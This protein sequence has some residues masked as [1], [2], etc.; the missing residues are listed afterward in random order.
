M[1]HNISGVILAG[2]TNSRFHGIT[3]ANI[4]IC[5]KTIISRITETINEIFKEIII[6]TNTPAEFTDYNEY[7]IV[8]DRYSNIGPLGG[9]HA[10]MKISS[11]ESIFIFAGDMPFLD[12]KLILK[13][14]D[15]HFSHRCDISVPRISDY[16]EPLHSIYNVSLINTLEDYIIDGNYHAVREFFKLAKIEYIEFENS[17][18][19]KR[20]FTNINSPDDILKE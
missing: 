12:K 8:N 13:Q 11:N 3:K 5:G 6:V 1:A 16:I 18:A 14:I 2:G 15:F 10:A 17:D 9:I 7:I 4:T 19:V 20:A